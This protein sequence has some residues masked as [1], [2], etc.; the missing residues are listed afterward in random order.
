MFRS[1]LRGDAASTVD[2]ANKES[3]DFNEIWETVL[4]NVLWKRELA[5]EAEA[6][7]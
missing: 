1:R 7:E 5:A 3:L 2:W 4:M 6:G